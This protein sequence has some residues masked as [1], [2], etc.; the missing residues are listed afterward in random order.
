[1]D[2]QEITSKLDALWIEFSILYN[3]QGLGYDAW[4]VV[5]VLERISCL[6]S[7]LKA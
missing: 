3:E 2:K 7:L 5:K 1:M 4:P 6:E